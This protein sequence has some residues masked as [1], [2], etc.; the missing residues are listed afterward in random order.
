MPDAEQP[1]LDKNKFDNQVEFPQALIDAPAED[2]NGRVKTLHAA[3][4]HDL[5]SLA[6]LPLRKHVSPTTN[7][8]RV[9]EPQ[10]ETPRLNDGHLLCRSFPQDLRLAEPYNTTTFVDQVDSPDKIFYVDNNLHNVQ[11]PS[12]IHHPLARQHRHLALCPM[13]LHVSARSMLRQDL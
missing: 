12:Q 10:Q 13:L 4:S 8:E 3:L 6:F 11:M 2:R 5:F 7:H 1:A 9:N